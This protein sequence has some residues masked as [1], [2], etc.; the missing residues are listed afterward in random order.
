MCSFASPL[1]AA[2]SFDMGKER[3]PAK[4]TISSAGQFAAGLKQPVRP[5]STAGAQ[6]GP[7]RPRVRYGPVTARPRPHRQAQQFARG[8][9]W[10]R[11]RAASPVGSFSWP[12]WCGSA[13][14]RAARARC[15]CRSRHRRPSRWSRCMTRWT[16]SS[17]AFPLPLR[18]LSARDAPAR[19]AVTLFQCRLT[20]QRAG[21]ARESSSG[22]PSS[23]SWSRAW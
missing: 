6:R 10:R 5:V 20:V 7:P 17:S 14:S 12:A 16:R 8:R 21:K 23:R 18:S 19:Q 13:S 22:G 4:C 11:E 2:C 15:K 9:A 1:C 3:G